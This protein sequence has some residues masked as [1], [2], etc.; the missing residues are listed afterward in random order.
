VF[1]DVPSS[2]FYDRESKAILDVDMDTGAVKVDLDA[3]GTI[4]M[5]ATL[6]PELRKA[7]TGVGLHGFGWYTGHWHRINHVKVEQIVQATDL[8]IAATPTQAA[9]TKVAR[10]DDSTVKTDKPKR[11]DRKELR[12]SLLLFQSCYPCKV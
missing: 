2:S 6:S 9:S 7:V 4:D 3:D 10:A 11:F 12:E 1:S 8:G 5:Q